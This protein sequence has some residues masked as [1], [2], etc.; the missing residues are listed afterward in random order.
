MANLHFEITGSSA[1]LEQTFN[2]VRQATQQ[3]SRDMEQSGASIEDMFARIK[4]AAAMAAA[5]FS[6][7]QLVRQVAQVRGEFQQLEMAFKTMLG[8][9]SQADALM[10]QMV[11]TAATTPFDL[12]GVANGAKSLLAYGLEADKVNDTLIRLGDIAAGLS[13][14]LND[15]VYLYGTTMVQGRLYTQ[16]LNQ[17]TGRGIPI[18]GELAKQFGVAESEVKDLV[19]AGKVGFPEVQKAIESLTNEGGK[20]GGLMSAQS[21]TIAGQKANL[22]DAIDMMFNEIGEQV[23]DEISGSIEIVG[24]LVEN[25]QTVAKSILP[26]ITAI[27][28]YKTTMLIVSS[29]QR[30]QAAEQSAAHAKRIAELNE[31][32]QKLKEQAYAKRDLLDEVNGVSSPVS[33]K[34]KAASRSTEEDTAA[35]GKKLA[36]QE[37]IN[38]ALDAEIAK[39][40]QIAQQELAEATQLHDDAVAQVDITDQDNIKAQEALD[41][42]KKNKEQADAKVKAAEEYLNTVKET[43]DIEGGDDAADRMAS[44]GYDLEISKREQAAA[45]TELE[46]AAETANSAEKKLNEAVTA[47]QAAATEMNTA[48]KRVNTLSTAQNTT[49]EASNTTVENVG[50]A[51]K[52]RSTIATA[53]NTLATKVSTTAQLLYRGAIQSVT[54]AWNSMKVAMSTN[55]IG[56]IITALTTA[57][58]LFYTFKDS[59]DE[60][61]EAEQHF[62][63]EAAKTLSN[64]N[65]LYAVVNSAEKSSQ[66]YKQAMKELTGICE[67]YG[68]QLD[69]EKDL[70]DQVNEARTTLNYLIAQEGVE[71]QH[72]NNLSNIQKKYEEELKDIQEDIADEIGSDNDANNKKIAGMITQA[73]DAH[74]NDLQAARQKLEDAKEYME[75]HNGN[76]Q[77]EVNE[78]YKEYYDIINKVNEATIQFAKDNGVQTESWEDLIRPLQNASAK[79]LDLHASTQ[80]AVDMEEDFYAANKQAAEGLDNLSASEQLAARKAQAAKTSVADLNSEISNL[81]K[82]YGYNI[83][84]FEVRLKKDGVPQWMKDYLNLGAKKNTQADLDRA[85]ER[86][87]Y[88]TNLAKKAKGYKGVNRV[89]TKTGKKSYISTEDVTYN[90][91]LYGQAAQQIQKN[92][93]AQK[94][95]TPKDKTKKTKSGKTAAEK[96]AETDKKLSDLNRKNAQKEAE[97][98]LKYQNQAEQTRIDQIA[99]AAEKEREQR[100]LDHKK[101][102][103]DIQKEKQDLINANIEKEKALFEADYRNK[104]KDFY[105]SQQYTDASQLTVEQ[106]TYIDNKTAS[107]N[108]DYAKQLD[109]RKKAE[110]T[111]MRDF[112]KQYGDYQQQRLAITQEYSEK[113]EA[114]ETQGDRL[115]L[116][117]EMEKALSDLDFSHFQKGIDWENVF[118]G[119]DTI[120]LQHLKRLKEQL[121]DALSA[122]DI[123]AENA[124]II[125]GKIDEIDSQ[126]AQRQNVWRQLFGIENPALEERNRLIREATQ[127]Q[128][129]LNQAQQQYNAAL[130]EKSSAQIAIAGYLNSNGITGVSAGSL[131]SADASSFTSQLEALGIETETIT[132]LFARLASA[133]QDVIKAQDNAQDAQDKSDNA[134]EKKNEWQKKLSNAVSPITSTID[135]VGANL[136]SASELM[137][138]LNLGDSAV[139]KGISDLSEASQYASQGLKSLASGDVIGAVKGVVGTIKSLGNSLSSFFGFS[140]NGSNAKEVAETTERLTE[141]NE[142]LGKSIDG[143]KDEI[144]EYNG[145]KAVQAGDE[146]LKAQQQVNEQTMEILKTQ[147]GYHGAHHSNAYYWN[148]S[149]SD[150]AEMNK[151][152]AEY[153]AKNPN[154]ETKT[155]TANSLA[156]IYELTPEQMDYIRSHNVELWQSMLSQGEYDKS[157]YWEAYADLAGEI[158][159]ITDSV[160]EKITQ[161]SFDS[162]RSSFVD[163]LA[164]MSSDAEDFSD[165]FSEQLF[166]AVL[167]ARI[168]DLLDDELQ[169]FY[170]KW[171]E[172]GNDGLSTGEIAEL[173]DWYDQIVQKG[174]EIRD[175]AAEITGYDAVSEKQQSGES[176]SWEGMS[177]DDASELNG[178]FTALQI[179]GESIQQSNTQIAQGILMTMNF[180]QYLTLSAD[181]L[182]VLAIERNDYLNTIATLTKKYFASYDSHLANIETNTNK[183]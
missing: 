173:S 118:N 80:K 174:L 158:E 113:I 145:A 59:T 5:G 90:A 91:W 88:Y 177:Q 95:T 21:Q 143:L 162:L 169:E 175:Q 97:E 89:D 115:K 45:A 153:A 34:A 28:T 81:I 48:Q 6:A 62:G 129:E 124:K 171:A 87:L 61:T 73:L 142:A 35:A 147:M 172:Y 105:K 26:V 98:R 178:R 99:D 20:F 52:I 111:A 94:K 65:T 132:S 44:A 137:D 19:T 9:E 50:T 72:A 4:N 150:Y 12:Q 106:Q 83:I 151:A 133:E 54:N 2:H 92:I 55:P 41:I 121:R 108:A 157:E 75:T 63:E 127:A 85:K 110:T 104:D 138:M 17:F 78:A 179:A 33:D 128:E 170:D 86:E 165:D 168:G 68:L 155:D 40:T 53:A 64:I 23:Q 103:Q 167:N 109:E 126:I 154:A 122:G 39:R 84:D 156:D 176:K 31:E 114:A 58:S 38:A 125:S 77:K 152:L 74:L 148:L 119:L 166:K 57:I 71:R 107:E 36:E 56:M 123:T 130:T 163:S 146:A 51:A 182:N 7:Q 76:G 117:K 18:I 49:V 10:Q 24:K 25:W 67:Q 82:D 161:T 183:L 43:A 11:Q 149:S 136:Q 120:S 100:N 69:K 112:L 42:A 14:P 140:W 32:A 3:L 15:I 180:V 134:N 13:I 164:D 46:T 47:E 96:Q 1:Q 102:L 79:Y 116:Q 60:A 101:A 37:T 16:D 27:G 131:K 181:Q 159:E 160:K 30:Q 144:E 29:A 22:E 66:T 139:G 70:L 141:S 8:S 93:D 135:T